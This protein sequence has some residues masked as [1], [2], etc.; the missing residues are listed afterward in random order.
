MT[1]STRRND[2]HPS[3]VT[4]PGDTLSDLIE[5]RGIRQSELAARMGVTPKF[6]NEIV[7]GKVTITPP[8][9]LSLE[10]ALNVPASFWLARDARYQEAIAREA[11][12]VQTDSDV[13]WLREIPLQEMRRFGWIPGDR[14]SNE[15][16]E[17]CLKFFGVSSVRAWRG[18]YLDQ[19]I[20]RAVYRSAATTSTPGAVAAWLR[21]GELD[22]AG[23]PCE[24][25]SRE[26]F[27]GAIEKARSLTLLKDPAEFM[28]KLVALFAASGVAV[29]LVRAPKGCAMNG[30]VRWLTPEKALVQL[31]M[32]GLRGDIFWFTFFHECGHIALHGKK[33]LFL[34]ES[35]L[36]GDEEDEA[37][38]FAADRLIPEDA[39]KAFIRNHRAGSEGEIL[40][41]AQQVG[42]APGIVVGRLQREEHLPYGRMEHLKFRY[43]WRED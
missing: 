17:A 29:V 39:W 16:M 10:R 35:G 9:A 21:K 15:V 7:G 18:F 30:A 33:M 28:P 12:R 24:P 36:S 38:R 14:G 34:E 3:V 23:I 32:R 22:A 8:T 5:E 6:I 20:G 4:P 13:E 37:N 1:E 27:L 26:N 41:F 25:F 11:S 19:T 2:Y 31:S 40:Q 42:I 43:A